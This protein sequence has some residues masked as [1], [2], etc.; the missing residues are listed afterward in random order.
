MWCRV[1]EGAVA[2]FSALFTTFF[3]NCDILSK[4]GEGC[5]SFHGMGLCRSEK[6]ATHKS[7]KVSEKHTLQSGIN[8]KCVCTHESGQ[9]DKG[10]PY[11]FVPKKSY[12]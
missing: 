12:P 8:P 3:E 2:H 6:N 10:I 11:D 7:K 1:L 4:E 5:L 9:S